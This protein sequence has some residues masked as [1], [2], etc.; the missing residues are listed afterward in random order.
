LFLRALRSFEVKEKKATS[1]PAIKKE[2]RKKKNPKKS[3]ITLAAGD[4][5]ASEFNKHT[6][7]ITCTE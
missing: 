2:R 6:L 1:L 3:K 4:N 5:C 7:I